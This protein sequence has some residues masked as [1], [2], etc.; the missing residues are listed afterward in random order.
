MSF[1]FVSPTAEASAHLRIDDISISF[2][3]RRVL[4]DVSLLVSA[5]QRVGLIGEN[6]SG[7]STLLRIAAGITPPD[8]GSVSAI[9]TRGVP[10]RVGLLH[11]AHAFETGATVTRVL[12]TF[13]EPVRNA[14]TNVDNSAMKLAAT[15]EDRKAADAY[16]EALDLAERLRAWDLDARMSAMLAGLGLGDL[17][18]DRAV[19]DLSGGQRAR[20]A[21][22]GLL[23]SEPD[24]L[25]LD[26]P[27]NHLDDAATEYLHRMLVDWRGPV[28]MASHDRAFLDETATGL[29]DLD[30]APL[31]QAMT[32]SL[33]EDSPGS[34]V[35]AVYFTG[36]YSDYLAR[37]TAS[38]SRWEHQYRAEQDELKRLRAS[39]HGNQ[40]VGHHDWNPRS[41]VRAAQKYYADR[42]AKVVSRRVNDARSRLDELEAR[43]V[44]QPPTQLRFAGLGTPSEAAAAET[45]TTADTDETQIR[46]VDVAVA[47]RLAP[48]SISVHAGEKLLITGA[49][50]AGKS[51]LLHLIA[52]GLTTSSGHVE[53]DRSA[54]VGLLTQDVALP[55][56]YDRGPSRTVDQTYVDLVG[57][58][59]AERIPLSTFGLVASRDERRQLTVLS[60]GQQR[61]LA[62]AV[63]L[64][65]PPEVLL[66]DEPTN[67]LSLLLS[68]ELENAITE[69]Q[70]TVIVA[71]HD[72]WL[73]KRWTGQ[74]L[75]LTGA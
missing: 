41:E 68:T 34:G 28:L 66:L 9:G 65:D 57:R 46:L 48:V 63:L 21:L 37:R 29:V 47:G 12:D 52:G 6:G 11:Q 25:L 44:R 72:R 4:T 45:P 69:Y 60:L 1:S 36:T 22:A 62:L 18:L 61:R 23:L 13:V 32:E 30:P 67:H 16:A 35:G 70:G 10:P 38:R 42:N 27:T 31:P 74:Q 14:I 50:G 19:Q 58:E 55:D 8:T 71:S 39:V 26:E 59:Q 49:N 40:I 56:P 24:V 64:A 33:E 2:R 75:Q 3:D 51:T 20:L 54:R 15:P 17:P 7:K 5:G 43:Q 73:R 53:I